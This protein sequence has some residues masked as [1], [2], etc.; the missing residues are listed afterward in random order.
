MDE[1]TEPKFTP[2]ERELRFKNAQLRQTCGKQGHTIYRLRA[3]LAEAREVNGK[4][5]RGDL[6]RLEQKVPELLD[7]NQDLR[8]QVEQ[9]NEKLQTLDESGSES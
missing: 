7:E 3:E 2:L 6:R 5:E 9:L 8:Q 4:I 1:I